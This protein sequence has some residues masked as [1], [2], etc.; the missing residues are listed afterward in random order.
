MKQLLYLESGD[1]KAG[2]FSYV[3]QV[4]VMAKVCEDQNIPMYIDFS[5]DMLYY[6][7]GKTNDNVWDYYFEQPYPDIDLN[8][9]ERVRAVWYQ[10]NRPLQLPFRYE[11]DSDFLEQARKYCK[12][13][14]KIKSSLLETANSFIKNNTNQNYLAVHKRGTDHENVNYFTI[15]NYFTETD[16]Y[17]DNHDQ[18]LV[19]SDEQFSVDAFK[20]RYGSKVISYDSARETEENP[21]RRK[22]AHYKDNGDNFVYKNGRDCVIEA[23]LLSQAKFLLKTLSNVSHYAVMSNENLD[24][25]WIDSGYKTFY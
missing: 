10:D 7:D 23:Y 3:M 25:V 1:R 13:Y 20:T 12:Q 2:L 14:V 9:Y 4:I 16:K 6:K 19:C 22:G 21:S 17:I 15:E 24:F 18:L 8:E 5:Q 11:K